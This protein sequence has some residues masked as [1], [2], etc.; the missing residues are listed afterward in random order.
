[1]NEWFPFF[2]SA[3]S[4]GRVYKM[5]TAFLGCLYFVVIEWPSCCCGCVRCVCVSLVFLVVLLIWW[6]LLWCFLVAWKCGL[7]CSGA[8][9][10]K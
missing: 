5:V 9:M 4:S 3:F 8:S 10:T 7:V 6:L 2:I 1:M